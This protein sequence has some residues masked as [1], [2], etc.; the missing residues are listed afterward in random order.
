MN[1]NNEIA[2]KKGMILFAASECHESIWDAKQ[3]IKKQG[4]SR[5][6][7]SIVAF[8]GQILV[9]TKMDIP[10]SEIRNNKQEE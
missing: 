4:L 10:R 8:K 5:H 9:E 3:Y 2:W 7:V 1:E 6:H